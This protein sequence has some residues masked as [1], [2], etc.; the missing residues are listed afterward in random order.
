M[1]F[2]LAG[3]VSGILLSLFLIRDIIRDLKDCA[4][5]KSSIKD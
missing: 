3:I 2:D 4:K 5:R 1:L